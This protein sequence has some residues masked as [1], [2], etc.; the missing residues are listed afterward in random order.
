M[1]TTKIATCSYC[2]SRTVLQLTARD[3][4]ELA[5]ASCG[6]PIHE[7][8]P[9]RATRGGDNAS[10]KRAPQGYIED[11]HGPARGYAK[12][13]KKRKKSGFWRVLEEVVDVVEDIID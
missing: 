13:N 5:C 11:I 8:K 10:R 1:H 9:M 12:K 7:M 6:A 3:G 2:H 4:H